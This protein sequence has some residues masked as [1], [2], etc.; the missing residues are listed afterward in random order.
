MKRILSLLLLL[1]LLCCLTACKQKETMEDPV[2]FYYQNK[3]FSHGS[4]NSVILGETRESAGSEDMI[5][6]LNLYLKGPVSEN[7]L[8][9]FPNGT[10][11]LKFH[12]DGEIANVVLSDQ[13][14]LA[15]GIELTV[16]CGCLAKTVME[17]TGVTGVNICAENLPLGNKQNIYMDLNS[18]LLLDISTVAS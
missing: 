2:T 3:E 12:I 5:S 7:L 15:D 1:A 9:T 4:G 13:I 10:K 17:L 6:L 18:L 14:T 8:K 16:A 11:L